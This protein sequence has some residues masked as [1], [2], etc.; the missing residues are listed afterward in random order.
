MFPQINKPKINN[1]TEKVQQL[2]IEMEVYVTLK[3]IKIYSITVIIGEGKYIEILFSY[4]RM[5]FFK[6]I[7]NEI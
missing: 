1:T 3:H 2:Q 5:A 7:K 6:M 4:V